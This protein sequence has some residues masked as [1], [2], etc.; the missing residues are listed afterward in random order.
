MERQIINPFNGET[1]ASVPESSKK[2]VDAA[3]GAARQAFDRGP[4]KDSTAQQ[5]GRIL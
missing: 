5:R 3:I 1:L 4:W 2:D